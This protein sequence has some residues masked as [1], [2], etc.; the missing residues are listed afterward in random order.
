MAAVIRHGNERYET[1]NSKWQ[2][3]R[4]A[5]RGEILRLRPG[6]FLAGQGEPLDAVSATRIHLAKIVATVSELR[7]SVIARQSAAILHGLPL[8]FSLIPD[9]VIV[10]RS[11]GGHRSPWVH[12]YRTHHEPDEIVEMYGVKVT[13]LARTV[14]DLA[15]VLDPRDAIAIVDAALRL[16]LDKSQLD[17][18]SP[19]AAKLRTLLPIASNRS[20]SPLESRS[21]FLIHDLNLPIPREQVTVHDEAGNHVARLDFWWPDLGLA[22]EA[23]GAIK[24]TTLLRPGET[25]R[26]VIEDERKREKRLQQLGIHV[27][28]W[29]WGDTMRSASF[30][31]LL[32]NGMRTAA[33]MPAPRG[34]YV[35]VPVP[36]LPPVDYSKQF[37]SVRYRPSVAEV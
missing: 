32:E 12:S 36:P 31:R 37:E 15:R 9:R 26:E 25:A 1:T 17:T 22:G 18:R 35:E 3:N 6:A 4:K 13:S 27:I 11:S 30:G 10:H 29:G 16:G 24:Y 33:K 5:D 21:R 14:R 19:S 28:R 2:L 7:G 23:D 8:S 20:E 34:H